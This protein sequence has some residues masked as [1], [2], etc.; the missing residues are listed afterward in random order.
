MSNLVKIASK[1]PMA[2]T[3]MEPNPNP[4]KPGLAGTLKSATINGTNTRGSGAEAMTAGVDADMFKKW[5]DANPD[6]ANSVR[7]MGD[8]EDLNSAASYGFEPGLQAVVE[9][10]DNTKVAAEGSSQKGPGPVSDADMKPTSDTPNDDSPRSATNSP[11]NNPGPS[12][13]V[14]TPATAPVV[15][16]VKK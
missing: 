16:A 15:S 13:G 7:V 1:L 12:A 4:E 3:I 11:L 8:D 10:G 5:A 6:Y 9:D 14:T 2:I